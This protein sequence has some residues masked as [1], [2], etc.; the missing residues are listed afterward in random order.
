[1]RESES[2]SLRSVVD[3]LVGRPYET[4]GRGPSAY[5]CL[6]VM[7]AIFR[8]VAGVELPDALV[9]D[10]AELADLRSRFFELASLAELEP[11]DV[12]LKRAQGDEKLA[13]RT[14]E[15]AVVE[16]GRDAVTAVHGRRV[17]R[18]RVRDFA[19]PGVRAYRLKGAT[20]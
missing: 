6:G 19:R 16:S 3:E 13:F 7:L 5:N 8:R 18:V 2:E 1:M 17:Q 20:A 10:E 11:L 4:H 12:L 15:L 9:V 14:P